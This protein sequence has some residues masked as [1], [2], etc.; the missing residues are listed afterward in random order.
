MLFSNESRG[1]YS[2]P[3]RLCDAVGCLR[4]L[5]A[6]WHLMG[7]AGCGAAWLKSQSADWIDRM[8][9]NRRHHPLPP[10][11]SAPLGSLSRP[12]VSFRVDPTRF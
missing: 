10:S 8:L 11:G 1:G 4:S 6:R 3:E 12:P 7:S 2:G 5:R 9:Q